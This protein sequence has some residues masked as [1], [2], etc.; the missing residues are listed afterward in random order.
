MLA[1][2]Y[3]SSSFTLILWENVQTWLIDQIILL[4]L[5]FCILKLRNKPDTRG[6][7]LCRFPKQQPKTQEL[8]REQLWIAR[9]C[10]VHAKQIILFWNMNSEWPNT[11]KTK[12][13]GQ[14]IYAIF[15][16]V[17]KSRWRN[18]NQTGP[19]TF[20]LRVFTY[21]QLKYHPPFCILSV[22]TKYLWGMVR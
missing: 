5:T 17:S 6:T 8:W 4:N 13:T 20:T 22:S 10:H 15:H 21:I 12:K 7:T 1:N 14:P 19:D 16:W 3:F 2:Y 11:A 9:P 18:S